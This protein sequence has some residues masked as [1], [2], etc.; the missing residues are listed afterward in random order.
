M[1][2]P[3][4]NLLVGQSGGPTAVI[5]QSLVGVVESARARSEVGRVIGARRG[6]AGLLEGDLVDLTDE[7]AEDLE[8]VARTPCAALGSVRKKPNHEECVRALE[9]LEELGVR[10]FCYIG[11]NDTAETAHLIGEAARREGYD[12]SLIHVPKTIDNDLEVT[13]H[14]PGYGSAARFV[15]L[16]VMGDN[17]DNRSLGGVKIDVIM[18]RHAGWLTA[19]SLLARRFDDDGPHL[20]YPPEVRVDPDTFKSQVTDVVDRL[21]RC[22]VAVSEGIRAPEGGT[23]HRSGEHDA[24]GNE[25]L[26]GS[27][28]LGDVLAAHVKDALGKRTRVRADTFGYLQRAFVGVVSEVDAREAREVGRRAVEFAF[29]PDRPSGTVVIERSEDGPY[30]AGYALAELER[31]AQR[32]RHLPEN[33]LDGPGRV[34]DAFLAY[35]A[36][37]AGELPDVARLAERPFVR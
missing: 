10:T 29:G 2:T 11:G 19:A 13:D 26:S 4:G 35:A 31:V 34:A 22:V 20:V 9:R 28:A 14:C 5:N 3:L 12:L 25:V 17:L 24:H 21:G 23:W 33:F 15:A 7:S 1:T 6:I 27:G 16:A 8:R 37:L 18:G 30:A 36:P 32:T